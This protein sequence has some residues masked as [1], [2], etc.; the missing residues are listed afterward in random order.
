MPWSATGSVDR[1]TPAGRLGRA[2]ATVVPPPCRNR[3]PRARGRWSWCRRSRRS[4]LG[5]RGTGRRALGGAGRSRRRTRG[6][7][8]RSRSGAGAEWGFHPTRTGGPAVGAAVFGWAC[9]SGWAR[10]RRWDADGPSMPPPQGVPPHGFVPA[11]PC[12]FRSVSERTAGPPWPT[13]TVERVTG[14]PT[15]ALE[16]RDLRKRYGHQ[17]ALD[18]LDLTVPSGT[19]YGFLG[20]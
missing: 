4:A 16:T 3:V 7:R 17:V 11:G 13:A 10:V 12:A 14:T 19:V 2:R 1:G 6:G 9:L 20:P 8:G 15:L 5:R 18:G